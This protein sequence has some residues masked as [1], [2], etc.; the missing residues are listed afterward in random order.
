MA[1]FNQIEIDDEFIDG[2]VKTYNVYAKKVSTA[3]ITREMV[4]NNPDFINF[5]LHVILDSLL[6]YNEQ[7]CYELFV[8][9][10]YPEDGSIDIDEECQSDVE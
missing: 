9:F 7:A 5:Y 4:I 3:P 1:L 6:W 10:F 2:F 8:D